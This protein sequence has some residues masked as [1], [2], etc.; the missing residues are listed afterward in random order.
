MVKMRSKLKQLMDPR[1]LELLS[2]IC[3][4]REIQNNQEKMDLAQRL[5]NKYRMRAEPLGGATNR[6]VTMIDGYA[7]KFAIDEQ[8]YKDNLME[9]C[10][11]T[12][13]PWTTKSYET[14]GY[15]LVQQCIRRLTDEEWRMRKH[16]IL[17]ILDAVG[18]EYLLGDVG[19]YDVNKT[20]WGIDDDGDLRMLDYAYCHRLTEDLFTCPYCGSLLKYDSNFVYILCTDR[21]NCHGRFSYNDIKQRQGDKVDWDMIHEKLG[22]S[23][24]LPK[25]ITEVNVG[26]NDNNTLQKENVIVVKDYETLELKRRYDN[27]ATINY[28]LPEVRAI[29]Q[30]LI[31]AKSEGNISEMTVLKNELKEYE[32]EKP[33]VEF[34][35]D[36]EFQKRIGD[37]EE[38]YDEDYYDTEDY[39][40]D[41]E[42]GDVDVCSISDLIAKAEAYNARFDDESVN[43]AI[44]E[45][46]AEIKPTLALEEPDESGLEPEIKVYPT[47]HV[48]EDEPPL[49]INMEP[50]NP[51][52]LDSSSI[53]DSTESESTEADPPVEDKESTLEPN[54]YYSLPGR[55]AAIGPAHYYRTANR[56]MADTLSI[57]GTIYGGES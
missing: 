6:Y 52:I 49:A 55:E 23:I 47:A 14:N 51:T 53:E 13:V 25:G 48:M 40:A 3:D 29:L 31:I 41:E 33:D 17:K 2:A 26:F 43:D 11:S 1:L 27:M 37:D 9:F 38:D 20:N 24:K 4:T 32:D 21:A 5:L 22:T 18:Q 28:S 7:I 50:I 12:E 54:D 16:E 45:C 10:L 42:E 30:A 46:S 57:N 19:Y 39:D 35:I 8:G 56:D 36:P 34:V 15:S 44:D